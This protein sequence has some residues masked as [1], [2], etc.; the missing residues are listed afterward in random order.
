MFCSKTYRFHLNWS[1]WRS[2][3]LPRIK[4]KELLVFK[5]N[6]MYI[7]KKCKIIDEKQLKNS[8]NTRLLNNYNSQHEKLGRNIN[9]I[10]KLKQ[11]FMCI[12]H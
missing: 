7:L 3:N 5:E 2:R 1:I 4:R 8:A 9:I 6:F 10:T 11:C 12:K